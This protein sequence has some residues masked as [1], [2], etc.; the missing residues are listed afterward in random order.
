[1]PT[2]II[3][4]VGTCPPGAHAFGTYTV[5]GISWQRLLVGRARLFAV[6]VLSCLVTR[7]V[8]VLIDCLVMLPCWPAVDS[9][10]E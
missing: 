8:T 4:R 7:Y 9:Y 1:M 10:I 6:L 2:Q 5:G 3:S